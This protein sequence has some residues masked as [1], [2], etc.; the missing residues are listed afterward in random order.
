MPGTEARRVACTYAALVVAAR[1]G[2]RDAGR[3]CQEIAVRFTV[4]FAIAYASGIAGSYA[5]SRR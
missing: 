3:G 2:R 5:L 4:V 1:R